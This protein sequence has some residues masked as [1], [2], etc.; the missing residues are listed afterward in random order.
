MR[1]DVIISGKGCQ[2]SIRG[3][4]RDVVYLSG[5]IGA[6]VH[7]MSPNAGQRGSCGVSANSE[8]SANDNE[9]TVCTAVNRSPNKL[10]RSNSIFNLWCPWRPFLSYLTGSPV[11]PSSLRG[12]STAVLVLYRRVARPLSYLT[13]PPVPPSSLSGASTAVLVLYGRVAMPLSYLTGP[14]VPPSSLRGASTAVLVLYGRVAS[15]RSCSTV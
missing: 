9:Y 6:L 10:W 11:P 15:P 13:G 2:L 12:A 5:P 4:Q 14:P 3:L 1:F 7:Y 8:V